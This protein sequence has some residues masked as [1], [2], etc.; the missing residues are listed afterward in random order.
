VR[1]V[2]AELPTHL[3]L[4]YAYSDQA[5]DLEHTLRVKMQAGRESVYVFQ[6]RLG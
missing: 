1:R 6:S 5:L 3:P 2:A 4:V